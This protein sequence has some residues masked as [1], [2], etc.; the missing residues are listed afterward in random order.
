LRIDIEDLVAF[1]R[2]AL[3]FSRGEAAT[4]RAALTSMVERATARRGEP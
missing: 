1:R 3:G 4:L 2:D